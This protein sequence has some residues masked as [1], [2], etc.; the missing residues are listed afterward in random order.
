MLRSVTDVMEMV[1]DVAA[2]WAECLIL[3]VRSTSSVSGESRYRNR[4]RRK[5]VQKQSDT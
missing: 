3:S 1:Y 4:A 2:S 5:P